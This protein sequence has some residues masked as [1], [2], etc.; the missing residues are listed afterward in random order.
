MLWPN[1][2]EPPVAVAFSV[3]TGVDFAFF[4]GAIVVVLCC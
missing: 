2:I 1:V 4:F 3:A